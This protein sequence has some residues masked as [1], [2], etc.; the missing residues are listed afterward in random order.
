MKL[1]G[2]FGIALFPVITHALSSAP[3]NS[4]Q[5]V[6]ELGGLDA[7]NVERNAMPTQVAATKTLA[8]QSGV[9]TSA[10]SKAETT[11]TTTSSSSSYD[12][13]YIVAL[14]GYDGSISHYYVS[15]SDPYVSG[16][17]GVGH[18]E[19]MGTSTPVPGPSSDCTLAYPGLLSI[20]G[21][22]LGLRLNLLFLGI[23][24]CVAL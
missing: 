2:L 19:P 18:A 17:V 13:S 23:D 3:S 9:H 6:S 20:I 5:M 21:I 1:S 7:D 14:S 12:Y 11:P 10:Y 24:A 4:A 8:P 16:A 15:Y 22:D